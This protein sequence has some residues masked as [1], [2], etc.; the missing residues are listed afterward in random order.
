MYPERQSGLLNYSIYRLQLHSG[1]QRPL[2]NRS[3]V[4]VWSVSN[5]RA[6]PKRFQSQNFV[7]L[8]VAD[9]GIAAETLDQE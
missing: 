6:V 4:T 1:P 5:L 9:I 2:F 7:A 3:S 8:D